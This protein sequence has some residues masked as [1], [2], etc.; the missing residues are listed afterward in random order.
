[1][2]PRDEPFANYFFGGFGNN[3]VD[4]Q[5][6]KRYRDVISFPGVEINALGGKTFVRAMA[7]WTLP[8]IRF[9]ELGFSGLYGTWLRTALFTSVLATDPEYAEA[10]RIV[11]NAGVQVDFRFVILWS[12]NMTLSLGA[13]AAV[14][15][16]EPLSHELMISLK[17]L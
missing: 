9:R 13:A 15:E 1:V 11:T 8:P 3:W 12:L 14:E 17:I 16:G 5:D 6:P 10:R 7:E 2:G 4:Y